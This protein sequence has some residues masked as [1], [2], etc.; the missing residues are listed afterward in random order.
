MTAKNS[1][2]AH[3]IKIIHILKSKNGL[4][5]EDYRY[6]LKERYNKESSKDLSIEELREFAVF[7]GYEEKYLKH[8]RYYKEKANKGYATQKQI[9]MINALWVKYS[10]KKSAWA[11]R[12]FIN[13]II[14]KRPLHLNSLNQEEANSII[15]ALKNLE[16]RSKKS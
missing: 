1:L 9:N 6:A 14:K 10:Y 3:L 11:L 4:S 7:L 12:E 16:A 8:K 5:E 13:N 15:Q 2:K